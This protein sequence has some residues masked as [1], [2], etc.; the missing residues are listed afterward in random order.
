MSDYD[1]SLDIAKNKHISLL[2]GSLFCQPNYLRLSYACSYNYLK[3]GLNI[4]IKYFNEIENKLK[5]VGESKYG[6]YEIYIYH[7]ALN[8]CKSVLDIH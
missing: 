7:L 1:L 3:K 2:P 4:L 8:Y 6:D 5:N